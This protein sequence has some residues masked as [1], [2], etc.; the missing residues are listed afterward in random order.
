MI[1]II[2]G[3]MEVETGTEAMD[4]GA[5]TERRWLGSWVGSCLL[6]RVYH[7]ADELPQ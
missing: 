2:T 7:S 6:L 1:I 4:M 3:I 5:E